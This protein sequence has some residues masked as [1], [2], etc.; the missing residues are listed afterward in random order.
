MVF[1]LARFVDYDY[2]RPRKLTE[3]RPRRT[4]EAKRNGPITFPL[5]EK[6]D[7][8]KRT[9]PLTILREAAIYDDGLNADDNAARNEHN[10]ITLAEEEPGYVLPDLFGPEATPAVDGDAPKGSGGS[11]SSC[12]SS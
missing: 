3:L 4:M 1:P 9:L 2:A 8:M 12:S 7:I 11:S 6:Y 10:H 5:K